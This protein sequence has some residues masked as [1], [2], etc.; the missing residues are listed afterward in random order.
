LYG[1]QII[2]WKIAGKKP[3]VKAQRMR[4]VVSGE[5]VVE[6][7]DMCGSWGVAVVFRGV[8]LLVVGLTSVVWVG[9]SEWVGFD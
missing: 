4:K 1:D 8:E 3:R 9:V 7:R 6:L 2:R 5:M